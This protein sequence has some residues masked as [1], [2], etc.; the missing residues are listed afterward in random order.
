MKQTNKQKIWESESTTKNISYFDLVTSVTIIC[1]SA[2]T[3]LKVS[4][5]IHSKWIS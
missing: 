5:P 2:L 4:A 3:N 1:H